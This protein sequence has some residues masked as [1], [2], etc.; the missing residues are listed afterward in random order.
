MPERSQ[1][2]QVMDLADRMALL[3]ARDLADAGIPRAILGELVR[4]GELEQ[5]RRGLYARP[6]SLASHEHWG[7]MEVAKATPQ[8]VVCL[9]SALSFHQIGTQVPTS[10]WLAIGHKD[11]PP[12]HPYPPT[13]VVRMIPRLLREF[14]EEHDLGGV[15]VRV[16]TPARTIIDCFKFRNKI[17]I[18]VAVEAL[19]DGWRTRRFKMEELME[20][21]RACRMANVVLPYTTMLR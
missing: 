3:R 1:S 8:G 21:A 11:R 17:G 2:R 13:C 18:D 9:A 5:I 4:E 14:V 12:S 15:P 7:L 10:V 19:R 16:T 6:S 20:A